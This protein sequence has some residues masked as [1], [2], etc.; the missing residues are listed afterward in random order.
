MLTDTQFT[1]NVHPND[2]IILDKNQINNPKYVNE[3]MNR[4]GASL[5]PSFHGSNIELTANQSKSP[6]PAVRSR[7]RTR[8]EFERDNPND[9]IENVIIPDLEDNDD[10]E[11]LPHVADMSKGDNLQHSTFADEQQQ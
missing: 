10:I 6:A 5:H 7:K 4:H 3:M 9:F 1:D 2:L 8:E 11:I